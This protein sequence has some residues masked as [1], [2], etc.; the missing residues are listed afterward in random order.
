M[1]VI[2]LDIYTVLVAA[3]ELI[4]YFFLGGIVGQVPE[5][6]HALALISA[7]SIT[8][9]LG[10]VCVCVC[11]CDEFNKQQSGIKQSAAL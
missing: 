1:V 7:W 5:S 10:S 4:A 3:M 11:V 6:I 8:L 2:L 9:E